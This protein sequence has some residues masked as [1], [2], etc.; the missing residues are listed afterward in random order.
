MQLSDWHLSKWAVFFTPDLATIYNSP[1]LDPSHGPREL[2]NKV[3]WDI[4]FYFS[5]HGKENFY[6]MTKDMFKVHTDPETGLH[7]V[8]KVIDQEDKNHKSNENELISG[9]IPELNNKCFCPVNLFQAYLA[10]LH[11]DV[12]FLWQAPWFFNYYDSKEPHFGPTRVG[13]NLPD[14]FVKR[15]TGLNKL[16]AKYT[17]HSL[18]C[19]GVTTLKQARYSDKQIM[20][21]TG[22]RS[23][24]SLYIYDHIHD[25]EKM[26]MWYPGVCPPQ[27][28][29]H[30]CCWEREHCHHTQKSKVAALHNKLTDDTLLSCLI[31]HLINFKNFFGKHDQNARKA[32]PCGSNVGHQKS[33]K[34]NH[35]CKLFSVKGDWFHRV[36]DLTGQL[37]LT[38]Q[39]ACRNWY[40]HT[41]FMMWLPVLIACWFLSV[42]CVVW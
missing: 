9:A 12:N 34:E 1:F 6:E 8:K 2:Q 36:V 22:H 42:R 31:C 39:K 33:V 18:C 35:C 13:H 15:I 10:L 40:L 24:A 38:K 30:P 41:Q 27:P 32:K 21:L 7:F 4:R 3:Q 26:C 11:P 23:H 29:H 25:N 14:N 19:T 37:I 20:S 28:K 17:N 16:E 5:R